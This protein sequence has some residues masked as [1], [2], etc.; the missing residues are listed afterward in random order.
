MNIK[1]EYQKLASGAMNNNNFEHFM[2]VAKEIS[3]HYSESRKQNVRQVNV[4]IPNG[5]QVK[6]VYNEY[7]RTEQMF[8]I[9]F[10]HRYA[11]NMVNKMKTPA[12]IET[13][14]KTSSFLTPAYYNPTDKKISYQLDV[15]MREKSNNFANVMELCLHENR[16]AMQFKSF[17]IDNADDMIDFDPNSIFILKDCLV[18]Q[19]INY[20]RNHINSLMEIDA[21]LYARGMS[22]HLITQYFSE[23]QEDLKNTDLAFKEKI[24][25][26]PFD[27]LSEYGLISGE[28][29]LESGEKVDRAVMMDKNLRNMISPQL[30]AQYPMLK[31]IWKDG[32]FKTYSE[33]M[34]DKQLLLQ[35]ISGK[36]SETLESPNYNMEFIT[37]KEKVERL[38]SSIIQSD[39]MLYLESLLSQKQIQ[40]FKVKELFSTHPTLLDEYQSQITEIF[41]RK[42]VEIDDSQ[43]NFFNRLSSELNIKIESANTQNMSMN[44][45]TKNALNNG[46]R[47]QTVKEVDERLPSV[48]MLNDEKGQEEESNNLADLD[49][50]IEFISPEMINDSRFLALL[51][52]Y[53]TL[54]MSPDEYVE[55]VEEH[56]KKQIEKVN[57]ESVDKT[58]D[59]IR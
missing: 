54:D 49:D 20:E 52:K 34:E 57:I 47:T 41:S 44:E 4:K 30:V 48:R 31:L 36:Q 18:M 46:V 25:D 2:E 39:P 23:H 17:S 12:E 53:R 6:N 28:Y 32:N 13:N 3:K 37:D 27:E 56:Y 10:Y 8:M 40:Y 55:Y 59:T 5:K 26:N 35:K 58:D 38:Y 19:N 14:I 33:I 7:Y 43:M 50:F 22:K 24:T 21:N 45:F 29:V 15:I 51:R 42:S 1:E 9:L 11:A 16:H